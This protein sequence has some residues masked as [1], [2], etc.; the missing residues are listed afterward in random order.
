MTLNA[1]SLVLF[2]MKDNMKHLKSF[3][4]NWD[5]GST[6]GDSIKKK[7]DK[8]TEPEEPLRRVLTPEENKKMFK[9]FK[10]HSWS[11]CIDN[12]GRIILGGGEES[13]GMYYITEEDLEKLK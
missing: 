12:K 13:G 3:I 5:I 9:F 4:E 11:T 1:E 8:W 6:I 7:F 10:D 2:H